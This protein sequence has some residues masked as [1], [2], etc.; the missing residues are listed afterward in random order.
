MLKATHMFDAHNTHAHWWN[1]CW[2]ICWHH[3]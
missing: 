1:H 3:S 2:L